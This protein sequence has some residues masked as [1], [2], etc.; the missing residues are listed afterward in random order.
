MTTCPVCHQEILP[1]ISRKA[2]LTK[3]ELA[4]YETVRHAG[5]AGVEVVS[6]P[7]RIYADRYDG[8]PINAGK[9][10]HTTKFN[11]NKKIAPLGWRISNARGVGARWKLERVHA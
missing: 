8:G 6:M 4:V 2:E 7:D 3:L 11:L 1:S 10:I 5:P 9:V